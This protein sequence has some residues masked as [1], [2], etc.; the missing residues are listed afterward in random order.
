MNCNE[1]IRRILVFEVLMIIL[2]TS[3][4]FTLVRWLFMIISSYFGAKDLLWI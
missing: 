2:G 3:R 1:S 4:T